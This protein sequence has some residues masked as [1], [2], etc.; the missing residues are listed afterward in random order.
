MC[1]HEHSQAFIRMV[2]WCHE[3]W[4]ASKVPWLHAHDCSW[5]L[6]STHCSMAPSSGMFMAAQEWSWT[7]MSTHE[8]PFALM[9]THKQ[10]REAMSAPDY[11]WA[12]MSS[13]EHSWAWRHGA[14]NTHESLKAVMIL[15]LKDHGHSMKLMSAHGAIAPYLWVLMI[16][17]ERTWV[18]MRA[19]ECSWELISADVLYETINQKC[20]LLKWPPGSILPISWLRF[21]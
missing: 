19:H 2:L 17:H 6:M 11:Q 21:H 1:T 18:I 20:W 8:H 9:S 14:M 5:A 3:C 15:A 12:L 4:W 16:A 7:I 10:P 13:H